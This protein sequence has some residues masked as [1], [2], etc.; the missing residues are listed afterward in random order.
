MRKTELQATIDRITFSNNPLSAPTPDKD[1]R[2]LL[3]AKLKA[4]GIGLSPLPPVI[5]IEAGADGLYENPALNMIFSTSTD[6]LESLPF[7]PDIA[8]DSM[9]T[10]FEA[11]IMRYAADV[12][13]ISGTSA[14]SDVIHRRIC[15]EVIGSVLGSDQKLDEAME[16]LIA[17]V[18][19]SIGRFALVRMLHDRELRYASQFGMVSARAENILSEEL[20][21][22]YRSRYLTPDGELPAANHR[23]GARKIQRMLRDDK[24][25][26]FGKEVKGLSKENRYLYIISVILYTSRCERFHGDYFSPFGS[27]L[28]SFGTYAHW[29]WMLCMTHALFWIV[30]YRYSQKI[31][32]N[33]LSTKSIID[34][35]E[36]SKR[37]LSAIKT[38]E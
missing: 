33:I 29:Y 34:S 8:F 7:R 26:F 31:D 25:T 10:A 14:K 21:G 23:D 35:I 19:Y 15:T 30:F 3:S 5:D 6:Y 37:L 20:Y 28:A 32:L 16:S 1:L 2:D 22:A 18:P 17:M 38:K 13:G 24:L 36:T 9:W 4:A 27:N 11:M 12:W